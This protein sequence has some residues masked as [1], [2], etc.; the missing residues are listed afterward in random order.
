MT[1][2]LIPSRLRS[3][4]ARVGFLAALVV[5]E[6]LAI[7]IVHQFEDPRPLIGFLLKQGNGYQIAWR[8]RPKEYH[9]IEFKSLASALKFATEEL[10]LRGSSA[11]IS[12]IERVWVQDRAGA[13]TVLWKTAT[14]PYLNRWTFQ[15]ESDAE[16]IAESFRKGGYFP[17]P[18]GHSLLLVPAKNRDRS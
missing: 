12:E 17:S 10:E 2:R 4:W 14:T 5:I 16:F 15:R 8:T 1:P 18:F 7:L 6:A 3:T 13:F 11:S 9:R